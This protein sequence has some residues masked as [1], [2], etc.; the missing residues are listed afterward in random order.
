MLM[1]LSAPSGTSDAGTSRARTV[2]GSLRSGVMSRLSQYAK[3]SSDHLARQF[4]VQL[5]D[6]RDV[7]ASNFPSAAA[8]AR[9]MAFDRA[10]CQHPDKS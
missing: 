3:G 8:G 10:S 7:A 9:P 4:L 5:P 2:S 1:I 6:G